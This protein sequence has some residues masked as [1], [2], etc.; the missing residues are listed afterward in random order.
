MSSHTWVHRLT[1]DERRAL[2]ESE[3]WMQE[4]PGLLGR[5]LR[6]LGL[7]F[8][9]AY[10]RLPTGVRDSLSQGIYSV[11]KA[12]RQSAAAGVDERRLLDRLSAEVGRDVSRL[13]QVFGLDVRVIDRVVRQRLEANRKA[14]AIE[15]GATGAVGAAGLMVDIPA[16]Y[17]L[18]FRTVQETSICYGFA[19][20]A[21]GEAAHIL[22]VVDVGHYL[23]S[24][25][26]R[27]GMLEL[28][29][30][31]GMIRQGVPVKDLERTV[32][33]KG[34]QTLARELAAGVAERKLSQTVILIGGLVGASVNRA[35]VG[36]VGLTAYHA[37]RRRFL[38]EVALARSREVS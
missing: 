37:Y 13:E 10:R 25:R 12:V 3:A 1:E 15:G 4:P 11:I 9:K 34:I 28:E 18:I 35:L 6:L 36:D 19:P 24:D 22:K 23:E 16:L 38:K 27:R 31:Q 20:D 5:G 26:K 2:K 30:I 33:A 21:P 29:S 8:D 32:V 17:W 14:A 7:P